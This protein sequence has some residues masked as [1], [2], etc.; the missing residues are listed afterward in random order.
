MEY[1]STHK[2]CSTSNKCEGQKV[3]ATKDSLENG[4]ANCKHA[5]SIS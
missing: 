4:T 1:T 2:Y 5:E 3:E